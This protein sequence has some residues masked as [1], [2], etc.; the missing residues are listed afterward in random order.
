MEGARR[1]DAHAAFEGEHR[2]R[3]L[4]RRT[5]AALAAVDFL[6]VPTTPTIFRIDEIAEE[7]LRRNAILGRY[8]T[9]GN[10]LD[11]AAVAVPAGF[12]TDG[13][14]AGVSLIGL[15]GG[16]AGLG[17]FAAAVHR[18]TSEVAGATGRPLPARPAAAALPPGW[19]PLAVVGAHLSGQPLNGQLTELGAVFVRAT[20]TA[21]RY[22][23]YALP[24]TTPPKPGL[25]RVAGEDAGIGTAIELELWGLAP[26]AFGTSVAKVPA[27]LCIGTVELE[28]G[29]RVSGFLCE[30][31]ALSGARDISSFGGW[32]AYLA[33]LPG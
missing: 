13:L 16:D 24:N 25:A 1:F 22:R 23:L 17:A 11:L 4:R 27:P 28:H 18:A 2:L 10:L 12:R 21:P 6:L 20:R 15:P 19:I 30:A 26:A 3:L 33:S 31:H 14:P 9:F 8:T 29:S 32:R 7:P 5:H